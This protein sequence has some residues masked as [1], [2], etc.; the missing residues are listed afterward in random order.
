MKTALLWTCRIIIA[1]TLL[2]AFILAIPGFI[3]HIVTE[4]LI[5]P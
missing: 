1:I 5:D 3:L 2:P 4:E